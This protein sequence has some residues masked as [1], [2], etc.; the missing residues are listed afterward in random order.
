VRDNLLLRN[1]A[2][3]ATP[4]TAKEAKAPEMHP[5]SAA[6][7][8]A[9][10]DWSRD[11]SENHA[12]WH[13]LAYTGM[14]RGELLALRWQ[15]IDLDAATISVRRSVGVVK[16]HGQPRQIVEGTTKTAKPRT[17]D[18]DED[19]VA[20]LRAHRKARGAMAF[21]LA[22]DGALAFGNIEGKFRDPETFSKTFKAAQR[23]CA[24]DSGGPALPEIRLHDLRHSH[25]TILLTARVPVHIVSERLGHA[26]PVVTMTVY[27]HVL[28]GSQRE[29]AATFAGRVLAA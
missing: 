13:V 16:H 10:L 26:S 23:L 15:D 7:L 22:Q 9:F 24:R 12:A 5:W 19:T 6:Q 20:V 21:Q 25:A 17:V 11:N 3:A 1:P 28:P 14:R 4:P 27:A 18:I 8:R 29:A 2:A